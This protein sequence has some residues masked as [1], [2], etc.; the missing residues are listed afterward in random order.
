MKRIEDL[1]AWQAIG[2]TVLLYAVACLCDYAVSAYN[3]WPL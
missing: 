2:L 1:T 3:G